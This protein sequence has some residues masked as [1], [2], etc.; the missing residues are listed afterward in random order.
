MKL[1]YTIKEVSDLIGVTEKTIH[2][3]IKEGRY[4]IQRFGSSVRIHYT[5]LKKNGI[6]VE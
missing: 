6:K 3:H 2:N 4:Q 5:E 1:Y